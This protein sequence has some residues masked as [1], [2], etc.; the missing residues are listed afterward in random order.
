M[1]WQPHMRSLF[2]VQ[3]TL[4]AHG[5]FNDDHAGYVQYF[6]ALA[7]VEVKSKETK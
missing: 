4:K 6:E 5:H 1:C 3:P 2:E 7:G